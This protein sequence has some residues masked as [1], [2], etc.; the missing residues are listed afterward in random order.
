[1]EK[2]TK[3]IK[4]EKSYQREENVQRPRKMLLIFQK[5]IIQIF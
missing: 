5:I 1:M 3:L 4:M 2:D